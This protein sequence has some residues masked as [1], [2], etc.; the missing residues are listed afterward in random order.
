LAFDGAVFEGGAVA[1]LT[2]GFDSAG[3]STGG[4][5]ASIIASL[6]VVTQRRSIVV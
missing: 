5:P 4:G 2:G 1:F 3:V 6:C